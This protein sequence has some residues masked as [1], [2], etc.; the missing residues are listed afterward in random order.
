MTSRYI[1]GAFELGFTPEEVQ[2]LFEEKMLE[3]RTNGTPAT[4]SE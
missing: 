1:N 3:W 2:T 4:H